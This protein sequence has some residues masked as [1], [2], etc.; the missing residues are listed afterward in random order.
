MRRFA[1]VLCM[2]SAPVYAGGVQEP[3]MNSDPC[4]I[5]QID[6][7]SM[8]GQM[9][10]QFWAIRDMSGCKRVF[11]D[12]VTGLPLSDEEI[13]KR[14]FNGSTPLTPVPLPPSAILILSGL[15]ILRLIKPKT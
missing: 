2:I 5:V 10:H 4:P 12:R 15:L 11:Y 13:T 3:H 6:T 7:S 14:I 8:T 1:I 9:L